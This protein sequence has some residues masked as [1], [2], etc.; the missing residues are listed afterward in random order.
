MKIS[1]LLIQGQAGNAAVT[2]GDVVLT[3]RYLPIFL[4][5]G[6]VPAMKSGKIHLQNIYISKS[7]YKMVNEM[8]PYPLCA[9]EELRVGRMCFCRQFL[10]YGVPAVFIGRHLM[11]P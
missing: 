1:F 9:T 4:R 8:Q 3:C 6:A 10:A 2:M 5:C 7:A 11:R